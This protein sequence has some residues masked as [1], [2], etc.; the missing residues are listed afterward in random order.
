MQDQLRSYYSVQRRDHK[1]WHKILWHVVDQT[2]LNSYTLYVTAM[3]VRGIKPLSHLCFNLSVAYALTKVPK[4]KPTCMQKAKVRN[5]GGLHYSMAWSGHG[6]R[7]RRACVV[8]RKVQQFY[9]PTCQEAMC[10]G[11]CYVKHHSNLPE[12]QN[13]KIQDL[14]RSHGGR[15]VKCPQRS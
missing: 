8:C 12:H 11:N 10:L 3:N 6:T 7:K 14:P 1:W 13:I 5:R 15:P 4:V 9:C 2:F